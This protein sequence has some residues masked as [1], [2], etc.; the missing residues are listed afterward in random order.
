MTMALHRRRATAKDPMMMPK[1]AAEALSAPRSLRDEAQMTLDEA[2]MVLPG[3]QALF[4]FQLI[5]M[6]F[7]SSQSSSVWR[8]LARSCL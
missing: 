3:I 1:D 2:C 8:T 7:G 4:G 6:A 5:A